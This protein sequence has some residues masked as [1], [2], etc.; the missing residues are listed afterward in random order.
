MTL[1]F[2]M[3]LALAI[4]LSLIVYINHQKNPL[5]LSS[6]VW[7]RFGLQAGDSVRVT[8][9]DASAVLPARLDVTLARTAVRVPAG[10]PD[11]AA[12]GAMFGHV[13]VAKA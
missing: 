7:E 4:N 3:A 12:L 5:S 2:F 11:T 6:A 9:G 1:K 10:H 13:G 8:Q